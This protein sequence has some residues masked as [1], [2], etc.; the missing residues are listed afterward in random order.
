MM[1]EVI[2]EITWS[3]IIFGI[4]LFL[5]FVIVMIHVFI[6]FYSKLN[7]HDSYHEGYNQAKDDKIFYYA[8]IK[9]LD[10]KFNHIFRKLIND[11]ITLTVETTCMLTDYKE[12]LKILNKKN[13]SK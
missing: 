7:K 4:I 12:S 8:T 11:N 2:K 1:F 10:D 3:E 13:K 5:T 9:T 6:Y